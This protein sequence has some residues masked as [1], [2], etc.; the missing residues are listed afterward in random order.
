MKPSPGSPR[1]Q[2]A[3]ARD[4]DGQLSLRIPEKVAVI[5]QNMFKLG[6]K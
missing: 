3:L 2:K 4:D 5:M 1:S 6:K